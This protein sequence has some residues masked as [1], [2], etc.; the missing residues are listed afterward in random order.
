MLMRPKMSME[1]CK[2]KYMLA[3]APTNGSISKNYL[4]GG[5]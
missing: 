1:I 3:F 2:F 4:V 5:F